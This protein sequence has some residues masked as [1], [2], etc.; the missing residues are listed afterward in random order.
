MALT[1]SIND[2]RFGAIN[3]KLVGVRVKQSLDEHAP[4]ESDSQE[5]QNCLR[6]LCI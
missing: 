5:L 4:E 2:M 3:L 6:R 1:D